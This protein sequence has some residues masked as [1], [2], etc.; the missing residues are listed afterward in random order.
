MFVD[1]LLAGLGEIAGLVVVVGDRVEVLGEVVDVGVGVGL[2][3]RVRLEQIRGDLV[4]PLVGT[5]CGENDGDEK[6]ESVRE[7]E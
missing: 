6:F 3:R 7:V 4:D 1:D 2:S 5:L